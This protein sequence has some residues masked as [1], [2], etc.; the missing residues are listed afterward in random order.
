[1]PKPMP[2]LNNRTMFSLKHAQLVRA[3]TAVGVGLGGCVGSGVGLKTGTL[4]GAGV[5]VGGGEGRGTGTTEGSGVGCS[6][7]YVMSSHKTVSSNAP[8]SPS[9]A[10]GG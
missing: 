9:C 5:A 8:S 4:E 7:G 2:Q 3:G 10:L 1:M 6:E